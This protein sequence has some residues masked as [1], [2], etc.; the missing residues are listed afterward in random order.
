MDEIK[1]C[2]AYEI[3]G[4]KIEIFP[5]SIEKMNKAKPIIKAFKG[6]K[7]SLGAV[8]RYEALPK[9]AKEYIEFIENYTGDPGGYCFCG[10]STDAN[11]Y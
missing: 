7:T 3:E 9:E 8:A 5:A 10:L 1:V 11:F 4:E 6:W 2:V